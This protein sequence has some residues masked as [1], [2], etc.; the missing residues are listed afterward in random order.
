MLTPSVDIQFGQ[1][2]MVL[3]SSAIMK[4]DLMDNLVQHNSCLHQEV[5][6]PGIKTRLK[7]LKTSPL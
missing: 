5:P 6:L 1:T 4:F 3:R 7:N 2:E